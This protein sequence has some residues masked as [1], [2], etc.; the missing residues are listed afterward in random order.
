M[1][2][3]RV[4]KVVS[5]TRPRAGSVHLRKENGQLNGRQGA[6]ATAPK[7]S[8][9]VPAATKDDEPRKKL[10]FPAP[11]PVVSSAADRPDIIVPF[12]EFIEECRQKNYEDV[13]NRQNL[14]DKFTDEFLLEDAQYAGH[15]TVEEYWEKDVLRCRALVEH[16]SKNPAKQGIYE[17][18][19]EKHLNESIPD[20]LPNL[21]NLPNGGANALRFV[22]KPGGIIYLVKT[23]SGEVGE[24]IGKSLDFVSYR[25]DC[26]IVLAHKYTGMSGGG[27]NL[28]GGD[29]LGTLEA[30]RGASKIVCMVPGHEGKPVILVAVADGDYYKKSTEQGISL[31]DLQHEAKSRRRGKPDLFVWATSSKDLGRVLHA[32]LESAKFKTG[33]LN[34]CEA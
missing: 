29:L 17:P 12:E 30:T 26:V 27:Q 22:K 8:P 34:K 33:W 1:A 14:R 16:Y 9:L 10:K 31:N 13:R 15:E 32:G 6:G 23:G 24:R 19:L 3:A 18:L 28:Q 5:P 4:S 7:K 21:K 20:L 2:P 11:V 25:D